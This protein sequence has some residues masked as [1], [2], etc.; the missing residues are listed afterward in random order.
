M[1][2][3]AIALFTL[4]FIACKAPKHAHSSNPIRSTDSTTMQLRIEFLSGCTD[5]KYAHI[6][7]N[8]H[9][10]APYVSVIYYNWTKGD[11]DR[12][13]LSKDSFFSALDQFELACADKQGC[14]GYGGGTG[15][16]IEKHFNSK[17]TSFN[18]CQERAGEGWNGLAYFFGLM[19]KEL[20]DYPFK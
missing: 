10:E 11:V 2:P 8:N 7:I 20:V 14:G 3:I 9:P 5:Q 13:R 18:Y 16:F 6:L 12:F 19:G 15:V 4:L 1:K 17:K